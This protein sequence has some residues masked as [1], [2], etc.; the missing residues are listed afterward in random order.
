MQKGSHP[1]AVTLA[2]SLGLGWAGMEPSVAWA[3]DVE[4]GPIWDQA[5]AQRRCP[6]VC[7]TRRWTGQWRTTRPGQMSVCQCKGGR[8]TPPR[9]QGG[10]WRELP[11][12]ADDIGVGADGSAWTITKYDLSHWSGAAWVKADI[13]SGDRVAVGP[14]GQPWWVSYSAKRKG[15]TIYQRTGISLRELPGSGAMDIGVGANGTVWIL[16]TKY[17]KDANGYAIS[18]WKDDRWIQVDGGARRIAVGPDGSPYIVT[19]VG[20]IY[21]RVNDSWQQLPGQASDIG[22]G[23]EGTVWIVGTNPVPGGFGVY[24]FDGAGFRPVDGG[25][26]NIAVGPDGMPWVTNT[27]KRIFVREVSIQPPPPLPPQG[28][29]GTIVSSNGKCLDAYGQDVER[30]NKGESVISDDCNGGPNQQ[31]RLDGANGA[32]VASNGQCLEVQ[33]DDY[34][35]RNNGG[36]V[37]LGDCHGGPSQQ[38]SYNG[39]AIVSTSGKCLD[40]QGPDFDSR[41]NGGRVQ[42]W[43]CQGGPNQQWVLKR[44]GYPQPQPQPVAVPMAP[45][46]FDQMFR[47]VSTLGSIDERINRIK[48][49]LGSKT[50]FTAGQIVQLMQVTP[51]ASERIRIAALLWPL[52][53]DPDNFPD[54]VA[55][56][57]TENERQELRQKLGR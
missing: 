24:Y 49:Y 22:V 48:D 10:A 23:A 5:H 55:L 31:W 14:D 47:A 19:G 29:R 6:E 50:Y 18:Y 16:G 30:R 44:G 54:V 12:R 3:D 27:D 40:L 20:S 7:R 2:V 38:W 41:A 42:V 45:E 56:F 26:T 35:R 28:R 8:P 4:A 1:W 9:H 33:G 53:V 11:G 52:V 25:A 36:R 51:V 46:R 43:D 39:A 37:Q 57:S 15:Y 17:L 21:H 34:T 13:G 32:I